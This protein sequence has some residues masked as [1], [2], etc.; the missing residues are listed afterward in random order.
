MS[1][2]DQM[3]DPSLMSFFIWPEDDFGWWEGLR[4]LV[5]SLGLYTPLFDVVGL[6]GNCDSPTFVRTDSG[7]WSCL[8]LTEAWLEAADDFLA[9]FSPKFAG[10]SSL[11]PN[12]RY[13]LALVIITV[14][15]G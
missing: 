9:R 15:S 1:P 14:G 5:T 13:E 3:F 7:F 10:N 6:K 2:V 11:L 4:T 8:S 12:V